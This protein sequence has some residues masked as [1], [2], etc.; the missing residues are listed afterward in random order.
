MTIPQL[1]SINLN[2]NLY[3]QQLSFGLTEFGSG[4]LQFLDLVLNEQH[5]QSE[6]QHGHQLNPE[7]HH[8]PEKTHQ[9]AAGL[10]PDPAEG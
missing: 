4:L 3:L 2:N 7:R 5:G 1:S 10:I 6:D 8:D 9:T